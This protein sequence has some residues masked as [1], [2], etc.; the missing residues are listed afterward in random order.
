MPGILGHFLGTGKGYEVEKDEDTF[1]VGARGMEE[2][3]IVTDDVLL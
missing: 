2:V 3:V 1:I